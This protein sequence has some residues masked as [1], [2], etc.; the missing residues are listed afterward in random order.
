MATMHMVRQLHL[1]F[2]P[3]ICGSYVISMSHTVSD[4]LEVLLLAK[5]A[6]LY[7]PTTELS[8]LQPVP[9]FETVEDLQRAPAVMDEL[10]SYPS[11]A[12]CSKGRPRP[13]RLAPAAWLPRGRCPYRR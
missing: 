13:R 4:L 11:T 6:G 12:T 7:D 2:G 5:E 10:F 8:S 3:D 9:L 1:E